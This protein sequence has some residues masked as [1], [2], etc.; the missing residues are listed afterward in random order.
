MSRGTHSVCVNDFT[1]LLLSF[2]N[3]GLGE[4]EFGLPGDSMH[5][6]LLGHLACPSYFENRVPKSQIH[7]TKF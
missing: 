7:E 2:H 4:T 5:I 3:V 6:Y 1:E